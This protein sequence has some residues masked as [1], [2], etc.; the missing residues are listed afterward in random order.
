MP[1]EGLLSLRRGEQHSFLAYSPRPIARSRSG[2]GSRA[3]SS[4]IVA[5]Y[6]FAKACAFLGQFGVLLAQV[7]DTLVRVEC[8]GVMPVKCLANLGAGVGL[9]IGYRHGQESRPTDWPGAA[10]GLGQ[11]FLCQ[12]EMLGR[13]FQY[14][15]WGWF[16]H[17]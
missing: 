13:P 10:P 15:L 11:L 3:F 4:S 6:H 9:F 2:K 5:I 1:H 14:L 8:A 12:A 16:T 17:S 7:G